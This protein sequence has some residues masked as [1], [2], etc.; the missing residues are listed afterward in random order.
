MPISSS[1]SLRPRSFGLVLTGALA[2]V[3]SFAGPLAASAEA[4]DGPRWGRGGGD[5]EP[6]RRGGG[7]MRGMGGMGFGQ[8]LEPEF[9]RRDV[10]LMVDAL[11]LDEGQAAILEVLFSDYSDGFQEGQAVV[12]EAMRD[13]GPRIFRS[14][15]TPQV[16]ER[17]GEAM[18]ESERM[19]RRAAERGQ[20]L[21]PDQIRAMMEER[22]FELADEIRAERQASGEEAEMQRVMG[23]M[24]AKLDSWRQQ[25]TELRARLVD[26]IKGQ[27]N[28]EQTKQWPIFERRFDRL[29]SLPQGQISGEST[30]LIAVIDRLGLPVEVLDAIDEKLENYEQRIDLAL[31]SRNDYLSQSEPRLL[32]AMQSLDMRAGMEIIRRQMQYRVALRDVNEEFRASIAYALPTEFRDQ[33]ALAAGRASFDRI[34]RPTRADSVFAAVR[35]LE[36][37][38]D[39]MHEQIDMIEQA[40]QLEIAQFNDR[41]VTLTKQHEP[42]QQ[43]RQAERFAGM[44]AGGFTPRGVQN[45]DP[46]RDAFNDR[47]AIVERH[48]ARL[49]GVLTPE[50]FESLPQAPQRRRMGGGFDNLPPEMQERILRAVDANNNGVI[51]P[52]E[53]AEAFRLMREMWRERGGR[54]AQQGN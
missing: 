14:F 37:V 35:E 31:K 32:R 52:E 26:G 24:V 25:R 3:V 5:R 30:D 21:D 40:Y 44:L 36:G 6:M 29:K 19:V 45:D 7:G 2:A 8:I 11:D 38:T 50:Q 20:E 42:D 43:L 16:R 15:M 34:Y 54:G 48:I 9:L 10:P 1:R 28:D 41:L 53:Q 12:T 39:D 17:V 4:Q 33:F 22:M 51:D 49:A 27:L 13:I 46:V 23:E 47:G 18:A